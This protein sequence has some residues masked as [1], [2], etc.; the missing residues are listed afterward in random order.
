MSGSALTALVEELQRLK[1]TG[2]TSVP[3]TPQ[4]ALCLEQLLS[5]SAPT[6]TAAYPEAQPKATQVSTP[7]PQAAPKPEASPF[8][9]PPQIELPP[10]DKA[11]QWAWLKDRVMDCP[12]C[13]SQVKS[14]KKVVLGVGSLDAD[15]FFC[16]EAP[17]AEEEIQGEPF[18][19]P[20]GQLLTKIIQAM[21]F[22]RKQVYIGNI[23]NFRPPMPTPF[24]NRPPT[25]EELHFCLPYL[26]AQLAIVNPKVIIAL[27]A[28]AAKGLLAPGDHG[29]MRQLRGQWFQLE[30]TPLTVTYHP[31]YLLHNNTLASKRAVWEDML[32]V[33]A[34]LHIPISEKQKQYFTA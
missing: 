12:V 3:V 24:G 26:K 1:A 8:A 25:T 32:G 16:G 17:G 14:G 10:G 2:E 11:T 34:H 29:P 23:M 27:G 33:L 18:V 13:K 15:L 5:A 30:G 6:P 21:G 31:S 7:K 9:Q 28:T 19:G 4:G 22:E 20:A